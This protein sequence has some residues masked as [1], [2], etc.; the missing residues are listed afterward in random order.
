MGEYYYLNGFTQQAVEQMKL[1][2]KTPGLSNYEAARIHAR[3]NAFKN[4]LENEKL[5]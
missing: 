3:R 2:S 4:Q 5:E 1:A